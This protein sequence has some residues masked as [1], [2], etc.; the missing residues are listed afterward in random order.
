MGHAH[1]RPRV[2]LDRLRA[3]GSPACAAQGQRTLAGWP[4]ARRL[5][6]RPPQVILFTG[7]TTSVDRSSAPFIGAHE[8]PH[9]SLPS[10]KKISIVVSCIKITENITNK[11]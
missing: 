1:A 3:S 7:T 5:P 2:R 6:P 4:A 9:G 10:N 8:Q 11:A